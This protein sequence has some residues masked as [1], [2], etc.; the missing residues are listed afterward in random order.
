MVPNPGAAH[1]ASLPVLEPKGGGCF[2]SYSSLGNWG[3][4]HVTLV[5]SCSSN[6]FVTNSLC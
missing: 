1:T 2:L 5:S 6:T 3:T 4:C